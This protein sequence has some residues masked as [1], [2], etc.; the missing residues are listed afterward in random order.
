[1]TPFQKNP[2]LQKLEGSY[3]I[4]HLADKDVWSF[5]L[6]I[7]FAEKTKQVTGFAGC[8]R[9]MGAYSKNHE[10]LTFGPFAT[11]KKFCEIKANKIENSLLKTLSLT[12]D[13]RSLDNGFSLYNKNTLLLRALKQN[14]FDSLKIEYTV[15]SR[16]R[17]KH[18]SITKKMI[19]HTH[20]NGISR[21]KPC[22]LSTW[23]II[24]KAMATIQLNELPNIK[25]PSKAFLYDGDA[26]ARLKVTHQGKRFESVPFDHGNPPTSLK[27]ILQKILSISESIE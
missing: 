26:L 12:T 19:T 27:N 23:E 8:N 7:V 14:S 21:K 13:I 15:Q 2:N 5:G 4:T 9:F 6:Q 16:K 18:I 25:A 17:N 24:T 20:K 3:N 11:T 22:D 1:M 10:T